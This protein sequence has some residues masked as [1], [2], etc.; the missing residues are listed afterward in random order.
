[1]PISSCLYVEVEKQLQEGHHHTDTYHDCM[2]EKEAAAFDCRPANM[3]N[4]KTVVA[5]A[6][7]GLSCL[8]AAV[9]WCTVEVASVLRA[10]VW[11]LQW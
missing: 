5:S 7:C 4:S 2:G 10:S 11:H 3:N 9:D 6:V 8:I 1:M